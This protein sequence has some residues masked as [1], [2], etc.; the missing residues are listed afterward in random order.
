MLSKVTGKNQVTLPVDLLRQLP[1]TE[2]FDATIHDGAIVLRP[3][4]MVS[5][6]DLEKIRDSLADAGLS[7]SDV[8]DAV[9]WARRP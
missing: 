1:A 2:Y 9:R 5:A 8:L 4:H 6:I 3:V 7:E